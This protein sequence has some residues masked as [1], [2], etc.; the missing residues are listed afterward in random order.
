MSKY[1]KKPVSESS[2]SNM[3]HVDDDRVLG[4]TTRHNI[5][6]LVDAEGNKHLKI[7]TLEGTHRANVGDWIIVGVNGELYPC[8]HDIFK[9]TYEPA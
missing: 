7:E 2:N 4:L 3:F 8:K 1:R 9:K 5:P 6:V